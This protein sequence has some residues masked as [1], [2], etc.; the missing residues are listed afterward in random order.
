MSVQGAV[1]VFLVFFVAPALVAIFIT[2]EAN[3]TQ[4]HVIFYAIA[5]SLIIVSLRREIP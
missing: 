1:S 4:W 5:V 3:S 2:D